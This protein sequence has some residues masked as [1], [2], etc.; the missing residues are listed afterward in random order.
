[1]RGAVERYLSF[2][3]LT[4]TRILSKAADGTN[5]A[6]PWTSLKKDTHE[7]CCQLANELENRFHEL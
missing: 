7:S 2:I 1:M 5:V 3:E 6:R 4:Y